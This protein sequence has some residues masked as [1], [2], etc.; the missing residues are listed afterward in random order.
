MQTILLIREGKGR[1]GKGKG[2]GFINIDNIVSFEDFSVLPTISN[3]FRKK[4]RKKV[5]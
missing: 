3:A 1:E 4:Y 5:F 2:K